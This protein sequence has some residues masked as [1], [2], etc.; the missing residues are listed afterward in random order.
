MGQLQPKV[1]L[2]AQAYYK[3]HRE[4]GNTHASALRRLGNR[5]LKILW[6]HVAGRQ[7]L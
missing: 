7:N 1:L 2:L 4:K 3:A 5:W 6:D